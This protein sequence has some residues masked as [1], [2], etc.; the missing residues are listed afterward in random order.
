MDINSLPQHSPDS[1]AS[2]ISEEKEQPNSWNGPRL[3]EIAVPGHE[4]EPASHRT[5][6]FY[7]ERYI[8]TLIG[9]VST[10]SLEVIYL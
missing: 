6:N 5:S 3:S 8:G 9:T 2:S 4:E 10:R 7:P 1:R